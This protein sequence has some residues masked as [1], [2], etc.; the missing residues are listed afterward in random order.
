MA[1]R[2]KNLAA[3]LT[4]EFRMRPVHYWKILDYKFV[5]SQA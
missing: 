5:P 4:E 2:A 1:P 3:I